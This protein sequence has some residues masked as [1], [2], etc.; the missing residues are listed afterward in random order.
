[1]AAAVTSCR[2]AQ[3]RPAS[4]QVMAT[5]STGHREARVRKP[6]KGR[7]PGATVHGS[8]HTPQHIGCSI[9]HAVGTEKPAPVSERGPVATAC[10]PLHQHTPRHI[11]VRIA[12]AQAQRGP[13]PVWGGRGRREDTATPGTTQHAAALGI[14]AGCGR[15]YKWA[16]EGA[17][18]HYRPFK[19]RG[20]LLL[21]AAHLY[22]APTRVFVSVS[23]AQRGPR[24]GIAG[25]E[26]RGPMAAAATSRRRAQHKKGAGDVPQAAHVG[27]ERPAPNGR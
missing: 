15:G 10:G 14:M 19:R 8:T 25:G 3:K 12:R 26:G 2:R 20:C 6:I 22:N 17:K 21:M 18:H 13:R 5:G 27:T 11:N 9:C 16:A 24:L 1:M 7:G 23:W 4:S